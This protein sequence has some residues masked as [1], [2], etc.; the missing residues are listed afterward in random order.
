[1]CVEVFANCSNEL[2]S[3]RNSLGGEGGIRTL[4]D[5][6]TTP[7]FEYEL[8]RRFLYIIQHVTQIEITL[9]SLCEAYIVIQCSDFNQ[10]E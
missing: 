7:D 3:V 1:M 4:G 9:C 10:L 8:I 2:E 6:A 5:V